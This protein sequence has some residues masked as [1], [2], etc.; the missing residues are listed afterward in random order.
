MTKSMLAI[1]A[2]FVVGL[3][4]WAGWTVLSPS[5]AYVSPAMI[6]AD[7]ADI[8]GPFELMAHT[9]ERWSSEKEIDR[10][11]LI[12]FGYTF[13]PDICPIDTQVMVD[14]VDLLD[15]R[16]IDVQPV[17]V[18]ID[19]ARDTAK[20]LTYFAEAVHPKLVALTGTEAEVR[21]AADE[22]RVFYQRVDV[23]DSAAEYLM[24]HT[25]YVYFVLPE[26]GVATIFRREF[27]AEQYADDI[28]KI[29]AESGT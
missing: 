18:T 16:G 6:N 29:L 7:G 2:V 4:G 11:T 17:F 10:A 14:T 22:Y 28:E 23:E 1:A 3:V 27:P 20:E 5:P 26:T 24:N 15:E 12:Y 21:A 25:G 13:C 9:G 19:P 8:G